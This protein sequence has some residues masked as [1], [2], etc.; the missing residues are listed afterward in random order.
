VLEKSSVNR[1]ARLTGF[2]KRTGI[3]RPYEF[4]VLLV[5][6]QMGMK[7][8]S[9]AAKGAYFLTRFLIGTTLKDAGTGVVIRLEKELTKW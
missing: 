7:H 2:V 3:L 1:W 8:P 6:G 4:L 9:L 5:V